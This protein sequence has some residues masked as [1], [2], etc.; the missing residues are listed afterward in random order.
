MSTIADIDN[1]IIHTAMIAAGFTV[2]IA[3]DCYLWKMYR[4]N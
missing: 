2:Q 1:W 4:I 3:G